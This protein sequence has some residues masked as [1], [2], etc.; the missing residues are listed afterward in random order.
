M[1]DDSFWFADMEPG[2]DWST[3]TGADKSIFCFRHNM[4][5]IIYFDKI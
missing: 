4:L 2:R 3:I 5:K 1:V